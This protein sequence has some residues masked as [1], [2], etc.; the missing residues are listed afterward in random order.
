MARCKAITIKNRRC[1]RAAE[2]GIDGLC[3]V[4]LSQFERYRPKENEDAADL[5]Q[6][7]HA[8]AIKVPNNFLRSLRMPKRCAVCDA[9]TLAGTLTVTAH[10]YTTH[11]SVSLSVPLCTDCREPIGKLDAASTQ[12]LMARFARCTFIAALATFI[13]MAACKFDLMPAVVPGVLFGITLIGLLIHKTLRYLIIQSWP[14]ELR[15]RYNRSKGCVRLANFGHETHI[16]FTNLS[17]QRD[18]ILLNQNEAQG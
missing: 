11:T 12:G 16:Q 2:Q 18:V 9:T 15:K 6:G 17:F 13:T 14:A 3:S 8:P 10:S 4:H 7:R 5:R 1:R